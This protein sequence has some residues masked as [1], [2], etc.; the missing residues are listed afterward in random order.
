VVITANAARWT[1]HFGDG[2]SAT[3]AE[4]GSQGRVLHTYRRSGSP[5]AYVVIEWIGTFRVAGGPV[6]TVTGTATTTGVPV[7]VGVKQA[8]AQLVNGSS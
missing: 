4:P 2:E 8:R 3:T 5:G 6:Q 1:W 7:T